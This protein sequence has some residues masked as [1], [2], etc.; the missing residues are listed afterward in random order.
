MTD[1]NDTYI[2]IEMIITVDAKEE[3]A[4][5]AK[6]FNSLLQSHPKIAIQKEILTWKDYKF[7]Y[8]LQHGNIDDKNNFFDIELK[9]QKNDT[10]KQFDEFTL[11]VREIK[12]IVGRFTTTP[13]QI[14]WD[15]ISK[16]YASLAYPLI[17]NIENVL[18]KLITKFMLTNI[19]ISWIKKTLPDDFKTSRGENRSASA[20]T[21]NQ[22]L[23]DTDF[24]QL[25]DFLF[26]AYRDIDVTEL[27]KI[28]EQ[29]NSDDLS[30]EKLE[31][32]KKFIPKSNWD[33]YLK[34][35]VDCEGSFLQKRW[36][37]LYELRCQI[38]HNNTFTKDDF[39]RVR[40]VIAEIHP[41]LIAAISKLDMVKITEK[42]KLEIVNEL[43]KQEAVKEL[44]KQESINHDKSLVRDFIGSSNSLANLLIDMS[45]YCFSPPDRTDLMDHAINLKENNII[46]EKLFSEFQVI[47]NVR[48][49]PNE[50]SSLDN[51]ELDDLLKLSDN[52]IMQL[53]N[54][55]DSK[56][57]IV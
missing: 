15:D 21:N 47:Y 49:K 50:I 30:S 4:S 19:G 56:G 3:I 55:K 5:N 9:I 36:S 8:K 48:R 43:D 28:L 33:K 13:P 22:V 7:N 17:H 53:E 27:I 10:Q 6:S 20:K 12:K 40:K 25:S 52:L 14:I 1:N 34:D 31:I 11:L 42:E 41:P 32:I 54:I 46:D 29:T 35:H 51:F 37:D 57:I 39:D 16:H 18:R 2:I 26:A 45:N 24:I 44:D 38:A 23:Y